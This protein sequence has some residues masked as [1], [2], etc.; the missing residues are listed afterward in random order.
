M[1]LTKC[2]ECGKEISDKAE[3]CPHCGAQ[4]RKRTGMFTWVILVLI[5][6]GVISATFGGK[7]NTAPESAT[8]TVVPDDK[9]TREADYQ[10][11]IGSQKQ[12]RAAKFA[13]DRAAIIGKM[14]SLAAAG[15]WEEASKFANDYYDVDDP[16]FQRQ[17]VAIE[18]KVSDRISAKAKADAR[19]MGVT[20]GMTKEQVLG[21]SWG[22]PQSV[23]KT[24][25]AY[26]TS[27]HWVYGGSNYLYFKG[28]VLTSI[29]H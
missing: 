2:R 23:N 3:S 28:D 24:T 14:K 19:K 15:Q 10:R 27:E 13:K 7:T 20:L 22:R 6:G 18:R 26:G 16:E 8:A 11:L 17:F 1:A 29:Q 4:A 5:V 21:S 9:A 12:E 25:N